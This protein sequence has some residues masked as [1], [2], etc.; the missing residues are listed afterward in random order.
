MLNPQAGKRDPEE[1]MG[2]FTILT[3]LGLLGLQLARLLCRARAT[4]TIPKSKFKLKLAT[5]ART[6]KI[7]PFQNCKQHSTSKTRPMQKDPDQPYRTY[8]QSSH[9]QFWK[10]NRLLS[11]A[12]I[13]PCALGAGI[14]RISAAQSLILSEVVTANM[15][16]SKIAFVFNVRRL[17]PHKC[18]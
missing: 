11:T 17:D 6:E 2:S 8:P 10:G 9:I 13:P 15:G 7:G 5:Q 18:S 4:K 12:R 16:Y 1:I 14:P 3:P